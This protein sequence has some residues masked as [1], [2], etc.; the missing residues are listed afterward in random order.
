M[1]R[2]AIYTAEDVLL[3]L[4]YLEYQKYLRS[5]EPAISAQAIRCAIEC[6]HANKALLV[7]D[8]T[9]SN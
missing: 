7:D 2:N 9:V 6:L 3:K 4:E 5:E 8:D 1:D